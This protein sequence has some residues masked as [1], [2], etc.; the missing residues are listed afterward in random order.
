[1]EL[2]LLPDNAVLTQFKISHVLDNLKSIE[3]K[4]LS[5]FE[6]GFRRF[7]KSTLIASTTTTTIMTII[8][9][10]EESLLP[11]VTLSLERANAVLI[12]SPLKLIGVLNDSYPSVDILKEYCPV[13]TFV[14]VM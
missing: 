14:N 11:D 4:G 3:L 13:V 7:N 1:L 5:L 6:S 10:I 8:I 2:R 12:D 9:S